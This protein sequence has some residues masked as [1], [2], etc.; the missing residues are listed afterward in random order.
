[1]KP[2]AQLIRIVRNLDG[3]IL[4]DLTGKADGRGAYLCRG[5]ECLKKARKRRGLERSFKRT[6]P[7]EIY[8]ELEAQ[9]NA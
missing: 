2:K 8:D 6:V 4:L 1:M 7:S 3:K 9:L 5:D